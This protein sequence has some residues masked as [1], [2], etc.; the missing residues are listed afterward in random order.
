MDNS[1]LPPLSNDK[2]AMPNLSKDMPPIEP[3]TLDGKPTDP[4][5]P[6]AVTA[7]EPA[8]PAMP[9]PDN[10]LD[11]ITTAMPTMPMPNA[12]SAQVEVKKPADNAKAE[13]KKPDEPKAATDKA[14]AKDEKKTEDKTATE[15]TE[16]PKKKKAAGKRSTAPRQYSYRN[17]RLPQEIYKYEYSPQNRHL[18]KRKT[19]ADYDQMLFKTAAHNNINGL[20][21]LL[22]SGRHIETRNEVG[23]TPLM[24]AVRYGASDT[25]RLLVARGANPYARNQWGQSAMDYAASAGR[26][27]LMQAMQLSMR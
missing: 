4:A 17:Q 14:E 22:N 25:T 10:F 5:S 24:V 19:E 16:E 11:P 8:P 9:G 3:L 15:S 21:A 6:P 18:P 12:A 13:T 7:S 20:R 1:G 27:D 2:M 26:Q 23:E